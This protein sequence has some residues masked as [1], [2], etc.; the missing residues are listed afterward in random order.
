MADAKAPAPRNGNAI[1]AC[2]LSRRSR[3]FETAQGQ[4]DQQ[5]REAKSPEAKR[6]AP[7]GRLPGSSGN[8]ELAGVPLE[9]GTLAVAAAGGKAA[10]ALGE[11]TG[12]TDDETGR[13]SAS[14]GNWMAG[15]A[16]L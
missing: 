10:A 11:I 16:L 8:G 12:M 5:R 3:W 9:T 13:S 6:L 1:G 2:C 15:A 7:Q 14:A 4:V